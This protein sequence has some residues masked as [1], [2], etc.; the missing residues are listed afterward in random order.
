MILQTILL[1]AF[2]GVVLGVVVVLF[3]NKNK[4]ISSE[5]IVISEPIEEQP[6][7]IDI[8]GEMPIKPLPINCQL[9]QFQPAPQDFFYVDCCGVPQKGEGYQPW[10]KR[11]PVSIDTNKPFFGMTILDVEAEINC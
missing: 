3:K 1:S 10:E 9:A 11:A 2:I 7:E 6:I 8:P 4:K 5:N